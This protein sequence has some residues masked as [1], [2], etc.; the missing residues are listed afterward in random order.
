MIL[1]DYEKILD[2]KCG[3]VTGNGIEDDIY[4]ISCLSDKCEYRTCI[5]V[6]EKESSKTYKIELESE[7]Y[8]FDLCLESFIDSNKKEI[9]IRSIVPNYG[10]YTRTNIFSWQKGEMI[11]IFNSDIFY[12][13]N[14]VIALYKDCYKIEVI[15]K[16]RNKKYFV[17]IVEN[18]KYYLDFVYDDNGKVKNGKN[19]VNISRIYNSYAFYELGCKTVNLKIC[20]KI[21]GQSDTDYVGDI[22]SDIRWNE[23]D[24]DLVEQRINLR[25]NPI[26]QNYREDR[27][28]INEGCFK[29]VKGII[30]DDDEIIR[31]N[32]LQK[33]DIDGFILEEYYGNKY[34]KVIIDT[35]I[36]RKDLADIASRFINKGSEI[37]FADEFDLDE[38]GNR[39]IVAGYRYAKGLYLIVLE[40]VNGQWGL[41]DVIRGKG[42]NVNKLILAP[43][44]GGKK[45]ML[46]IWEISDIWSTL[47][48]YSKDK[49]GIYNY[50]GIST[51]FNNLEVEDIDSNGEFEIIVWTRES[52]EAY[53]VD[54]Y[55]IQNN[56]LIKARDLYDK[57]YKYLVKYYEGLVN[58]NPSSPIYWYYL[59][60]A[61]FIAGFLE[62]AL[63]SINMDLSFQYPYYST[64]EAMLLKEKIEGKLKK[65]ENSSF[66]Y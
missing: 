31:L 48:I 10:G 22:E 62:E 33:E 1:N 12:E 29:E 32:E 25:G 53:K 57:Y 14:K 37:L 38:D 41:V 65:V 11:E 3:D 39:E 54:I 58:K 5:L 18:F 7:N 51:P 34:G 36:K 21:L 60:E 27:I 26:N 46:A 44:E 17:D 64:D 6:K 40:E 59:A 42:Y 20:Q 55:R 63:K 50:L 61:Q 2:H 16:S 24:F 45:F 15:N 49:F 35:K 47:D 23:E 8:N 9:L 30:E 4:L 19:K 28:C 66:I 13:N 56:N 43:L 52:G